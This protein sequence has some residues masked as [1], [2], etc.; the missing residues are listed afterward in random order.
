MLASWRTASQ[1]NQEAQPV[2]FQRAELSHSP[3]PLL[4][5][6]HP[7]PRHLLR[8]RPHL[9]VTTLIPKISAIF[10][11]ANI[12][13]DGGFQIQIP[14]TG[15]FAWR[16]IVD[17]LYS[18]SVSFAVVESARVFGNFGLSLNVSASDTQSPFVALVSDEWSAGDGFYEISW[19]VHS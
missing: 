17:P 18:G 15:G 9:Q 2:Q 1:S 12:L 5:H 4:E 8:R 16:V 10:S 3:L 6:R 7:V 13:D 11:A 19:F 14:S